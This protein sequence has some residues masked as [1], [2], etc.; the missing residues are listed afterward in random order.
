MLATSDA[1][2]NIR[3]GIAS[4]GG[5]DPFVKGVAL[6]GTGLA[7]LAGLS[8]AVWRGRRRS[9]FVD[10]RARIP[11]DQDVGVLIETKKKTAAKGS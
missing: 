8:V 5:D 2:Q 3:E 10:V 4:I 11:A 7:A 9:D 1:L 6:I